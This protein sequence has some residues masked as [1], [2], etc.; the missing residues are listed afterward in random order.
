MKVLKKRAIELS[1]GADGASKASAVYAD[2]PLVKFWINAHSVFY[3]KRL[4]G[5]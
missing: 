4:T 5:R 3:L 2:E 1:A